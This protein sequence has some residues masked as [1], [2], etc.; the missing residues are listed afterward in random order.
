[1]EDDAEF[2]PVSLCVGRYCSNPV[3]FLFRIDMA[4]PFT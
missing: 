4:I 3:I 1:M 2:T